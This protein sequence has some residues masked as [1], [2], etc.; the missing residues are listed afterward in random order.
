M[1]VT[2]IA[3]KAARTALNVAGTAR[4]K[5][6]LH[7]GKTE[8]YDWATDKNVQSGG[9]DIPVEGV[10]YKETKLQAGAIGTESVFLVHGDDAP[11]GIFEADTLTRTKTGELWNIYQVDPIPTE[12]VILV[13][14][15][16]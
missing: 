4:E 7:L 11:N 2:A 14:V 3:K 6:T 5:V 13:R 1:D 12:A 9:G 15:R 16:K 10:W 8:T